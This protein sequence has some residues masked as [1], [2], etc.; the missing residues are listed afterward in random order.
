MVPVS[1]DGFT[2]TDSD[3]VAWEFAWMPWVGV[4]DEQGRAQKVPTRPEW[5]LTPAGSWQV[6]DTYFDR[7][8][9]SDL[10]FGGPWKQLVRPGQGK[11]KPGWEAGWV[12]NQ[13][14]GLWVVDVDNLEH[15]RRRMEELGI[16]P[17]VTWAQSTGRIGS[18]QHLLF[19]SR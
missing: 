10:D 19:D 8:T 6:P 14:T 2:P 9:P 12:C 17:P 5:Q 4:I 11:W 13:R 7:N 15:F 3:G 1:G 18:G 16:A